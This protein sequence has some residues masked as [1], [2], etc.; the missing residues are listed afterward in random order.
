[1]VCFHIALVFL[2]QTQF[3]HQ[4]GRK[5]KRAYFVN[6]L[7]QEVVSDLGHDPQMLHAHADSDLWNWRSLF[8][9][10]PTHGE[11]QKGTIRTDLQYGGIDIELGWLCG[12]R[13]IGF[14]RYCVGHFLS[15]LV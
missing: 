7:L 3:L 11:V 9:R 15:P 6:V 14:L 8:T 12:L 1:M 13:L 2:F 5:G 4:T 10:R